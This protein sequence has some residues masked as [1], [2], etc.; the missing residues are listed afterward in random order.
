MYVN[1]LARDLG[2]RDVEDVEVL[3]TDEI[4]QQIERAF[5]RFEEHL[6][7]VRRNVEVARQL[8][9]RLAFDDGKRHL[10]LARNA[11]L[12]KHGRGRGWHQAQVRLGRFN[13]LFGQLRNPAAE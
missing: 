6:E 8:G 7:G 9:D 4:E 2:D 11:G 13:D 3:P 10:A 12:R 5:E 1:V